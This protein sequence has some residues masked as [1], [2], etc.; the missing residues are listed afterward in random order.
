[1]KKISDFTEKLLLDHPSEISPLS[2]DFFTTAYTTTTTTTTTQDREPVQ[3]QLSNIP[4]QQE[5]DSRIN[6]LNQIRAAY[7]TDAVLFSYQN[8]SFTHQNLMR[9]ALDILQDFEEG[10]PVRVNFWLNVALDCLRFLRLSRSEWCFFMSI[11]PDLQ[12]RMQAEIRRAFGDDKVQNVPDSIIE[13][14][15]E[16]IKLIESRLNESTPHPNQEELVNDGEPV[17]TFSQ[18]EEERGGQGPHYVG[19]PEEQE[20]VTSPSA[21][22]SHAFIIHS[23]PTPPD[24]IL[25]QTTTPQITH[26]MALQ[27][28]YPFQTCRTLPA[29][30]SFGHSPFVCQD[31]STRLEAIKGAIH[32][33]YQHYQQG[34]AQATFTSSLELFTN[35]VTD[36]ELKNFNYSPLEE[37]LA[38]SLAI[39]L[40]KLGDSAEFANEKVRPYFCHRILSILQFAVKNEEFLESLTQ[41]LGEVIETCSDGA[42]FLANQMEVLEKVKKVSDDGCLKV[43]K[44]TYAVELLKEF[45]IKKLVQLKSSGCKVD[46]GETHLRFQVE[47]REVLQLPTSCTSMNFPSWAK[48][49]EVDLIEAIDFVK[50]GSADVNAFADYLVSQKFWVKKIEKDYARERKK[51]L[52]GIRLEMKALD[53]QMGEISDQKYLTESTNLKQKYE[54]AIA[55]WQKATTLDI[56]KS[57]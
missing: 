47:L 13:E 1:M 16:L 34:Q 22:S 23:F 9:E 2:T 45:S 14:A 43:L 31:F 18:P 28:F 46:P 37:P 5:E 56:L 15:V 6:R 48:I 52:K 39:W 42:L 49:D 35:H 11:K 17:Q 10:D 21:F 29:P 44:G 27:G 19:E 26:G 36:T 38:E 55:S 25:T 54:K 53:S 24:A 7:Q 8:S 32:P 20:L 33:G 12:I 51:Y 4:V 40:T 3:T 50:S 57:I 30:N 41:E